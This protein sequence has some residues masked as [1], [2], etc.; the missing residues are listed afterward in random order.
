[1]PSYRILL[2]LAA[3][4]VAVSSPA[5]AQASGKDPCTLLTAAEVST[6]LG[7]TSRPGRP[8]LG[9]T[10]VCYFAADTG[11]NT[12]APS[13][14]LMVMTPVAFQNQSHMP[15][16]LAGHAVAGLGDE[17]YYVSS[18]GYAKVLV[19][20]GTVMFSVTIVAGEKT[21]ATPAQ[22]VEM[23]KSLATKAL[24]HI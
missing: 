10:H 9:S 16:P 20:K 24:A 1:M 14:T 23:E 15:G 17:A 2:A 7:I 5:L 8:F 12:G 3:T 18:G 21:K 19:R 6:A 13:V 4:S 22:V 11:Y